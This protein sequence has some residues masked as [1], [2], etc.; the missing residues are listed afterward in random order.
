VRLNIS[1]AKGKFQRKEP[2][3]ARDLALRFKQGGQKL[4]RFVKAK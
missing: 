2:T 1:I 4:K 3:L